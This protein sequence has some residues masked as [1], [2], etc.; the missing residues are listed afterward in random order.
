MINMIV[1][2]ADGRMG[3]S[4][5]NIAKADPNIRITGA[6]EIDSS[7]AIGTGNPQITKISDLEKLVN[8]GDVLVDFTVAS[9]TIN[10]LRTAVKKNAKMVIGTTGLSD[11]QKEEISKASKIIPVMFSP[12]MSVGIN[13]LIDM[14]EQLAKKI[15]NYEVEIVEFHHNKKKDAPSGT[16]LRLAEAVA[17][18]LGRDMKKHGVY[19]RHGIGAERTQEEIGIHAV[20][21]GDIVGDHTIYFAGLGERIEITHRAHSRENLASGAVKASKWLEDKKPGLYD[22]L[23]VLGL[24]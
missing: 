14:V 15:P 2:G 6:V 16:A 3:R 7:P 4:I 10:V 18:G 17:K 12:N 11:E 13:I 22:M 21:C 8:P 9:N 24:K 5:I 23:D 1:C 19:G 20:R